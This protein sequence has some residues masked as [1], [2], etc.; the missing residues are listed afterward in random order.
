MGK[1]KTLFLGIVVGMAAIFIIRSCTT[2]QIQ[3]WVATTESIRENEKVV[4]IHL[5][6]A[7]K[8]AC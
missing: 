8:V 3:V 5:A 2:A 4:E 7:I 1:Y 6:T